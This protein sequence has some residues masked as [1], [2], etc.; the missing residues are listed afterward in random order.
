[1]KKVSALLFAVLIFPVF[2]FA[3]AGQ[4]LVKWQGWS[5]NLFQR[6]QKENKLV[7]L[8]LEAVWCHWCHVIDTQTYSKPEIAEVINSKFIPVRVDQDSRPDLS[9]KYEEYG[10]PATIIFNPKGLELNKLAGYVEAERMADILKTAIEHPEQ[11]FETAP[12][13]TFS[14]NPDLAVEVRQRLEKRHYDSADLQVGGLNTFHRF[15]VPD[16]IEYSMF[17]ALEGSEIDIKMAKLFLDKCIKLIDPVWGGGYQYSTDRDWDHPHFEKIMSTQSNFIKT[18]AMGYQ[19]WKD[20]KYLRAAQAVYSFMKTFMTS[21]EGAFYTSMDADVIKGQHSAEYFELSDSDRRKQGI[22]AIDKHVYSRENGWMIFAL[23]HLYAA[24]GNSEVLAD[25]VRAADW[26]LAKRSLGGGFRHDENDKAGPFLDDSLYMGR[27]ALALYA[28]T[29][30]RKWL[31]VAVGAADFIAQNFKLASEP[32][33][34]SAKVMATDLVKPIRQR[35]ANI[36]MGRFANLLSHYTGKEEY[37][38]MGQEA[39]RYI[40]SP[41]LAFDNVTEPGIL[42]VAEELSQNPTHITIVGKK[43]DPQ[44]NVLF[45]AGRK[46]FSTYK[47]LEWW[48][49]R[50]GPMPNPDVAYPELSKAAAFVCSNRRCSLPIFNPEGIQKKLDEYR[51]KPKAQ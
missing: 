32:G 50:E 41:A 44:A 24:T 39:L 42:M 8:Y 11:P 1:M 19:L 16:A 51:S 34:Y 43:D 13:P 9:T 23:A 20:D 49:K 7:I 17:K 26:I 29:A 38:K 3:E 25:A 33:Y 2:A 15:L 40:G 14:E 6:A 22:P 5:D 48:D 31:N 18:Y 45:D 30:D 37:K 36:A 21:P 12:A 46:I 35:E 27:A 4:S 28:V 10:W 47:R